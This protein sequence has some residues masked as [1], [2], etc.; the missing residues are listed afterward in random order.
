MLY[1]VITREAEDFDE[2]AVEIR[3]EEM[4]KKE[5]DAASQ[6]ACGCPSAGIQFFIPK[7]AA[8]KSEE[9]A[10]ALSH[11]PIQIR[12]IPPNAPFL[13]NADLLVLADCAAVAA[14]GLHTDFLR[15][16]VV[17]MGCP[18]FDDAPS[19]VQKFSEIFKTAGRN[20]FV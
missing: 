5:A 7:A 17:M 6:K 14:S 13:K 19:Y 15:N 18:K 8:G 1:E 11:W 3:L 20:N 4:R 10:S 2:K 9:T 16:R 12:L